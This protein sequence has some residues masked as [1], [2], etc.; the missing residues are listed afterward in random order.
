MGSRCTT[1]LGVSSHEEYV[2]ILGIDYAAPETETEFLG[3]AAPQ[4]RPF[5]T[6]SLVRLRGAAP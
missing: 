4:A 1:S 2:S 5:M 6:L 3:T